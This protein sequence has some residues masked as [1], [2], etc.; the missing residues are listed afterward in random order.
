[1]GKTPSLLSEQPKVRLSFVWRRGACMAPPSLFQ[2]V[3]RV[4]L[5]G[6]LSVLHPG[7]HLGGISEH[8]VRWQL[9]G[10]ENSQRHGMRSDERMGFP[11]PLK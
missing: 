9:S 11:T 2:D 3:Q 8:H 1:M 4:L 6:T 7:W 10:A 5:E